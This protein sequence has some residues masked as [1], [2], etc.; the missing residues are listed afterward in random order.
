M[1]VSEAVKTLLAVRSYQDKPAELKTIKQVVEA[2][3]LTASST[4]R[5]D[6]DFIA[7]TDRDRLEQL[8]SLASGG[9]Y[10]A[11]AAFAVAV[12]LGDYRSAL[13]DAGRAVQDMMLVAWEQ[14]LG[15]NW[16]GKV[17]SEEIRQLLQ[18]PEDRTVITIVPFGYPK[19]DLGAGIKDRKPFDEVVHH[20]RYGEHF[21]D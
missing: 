5:Q 2:A 6:W 16:V 21:E 13:G 19:R 1:Q 4:N 14:G 18:V 8:G 17:N 20:N 3:R 15:S 11:G 9:S 10:I 12:L 7:I